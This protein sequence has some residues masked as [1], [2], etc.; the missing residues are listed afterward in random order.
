MRAERLLRLAETEAR[1]MRGAAAADVAAMIAKAQAD[2]EAHRHEVEQQL[3]ERSTAL[4]R[5]ARD[6]T[7]R[8]RRA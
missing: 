6:R 2:A 8:L 3:I 4:D 1:E 5:Q 7:G